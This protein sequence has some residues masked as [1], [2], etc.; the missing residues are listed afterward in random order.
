MSDFLRRNAGLLIAGAVILFLIGMLVF[1]T[2][3]P[4]APPLPTQISTPTLTHTA[5]PTQTP[6][7]SATPSEK[8]TGTM[9]IMPEPSKTCQTEQ[10]EVQAVL[11]ATIPENL[12]GVHVERFL[13]SLYEL[14]LFIVNSGETKTI[15]V[16][17]PSGA[18]WNLDLAQFYY[19]RPDGTLDALWA[20]LG[21]AP[22]GT[23]S[24]APTPYYTFNN[25]DNEGWF[26]SQEALAKLSISGQVFNLIFPEVFIQPDGIH[27]NQC[28]VT[29]NLL[30]EVACRLGPILDP[31]GSAE[32][33]STGTPLESWFAFGWYVLPNSQN[34]FVNPFPNTVTLPETCP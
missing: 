15:A 3:Y 25:V 16:E 22:N 6:N 5:R 13:G 17:E 34:S 8:P 30:P 21:F 9:T 23:P 4:S 12:W 1:Q 20:T 29:L 31:S 28:R 26:S 33:V 27:W 2:S 19:L 32:I 14:S 11:Q 10:D 24:T 7:P 18:S